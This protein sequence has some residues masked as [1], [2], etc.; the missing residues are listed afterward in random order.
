MPLP[1]SAKGLPRLVW[2]PGAINYSSAKQPTAKQYPSA[3]QNELK[4]LLKL[5]LGSMEHD[6]I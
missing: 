2:Q 3:L 1:P 4:A 6:I 5:P